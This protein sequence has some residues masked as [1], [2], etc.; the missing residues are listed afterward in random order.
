MQ[1]WSQDPDAQFV[2]PKQ[3]GPLGELPRGVC[4][5]A[6]AGL[7]VG[8][9]KVDNLE[10]GAG[11]GDWSNGHIGFLVI[12]N[13]YVQSILDILIRFL[14]ILRFLHIPTILNITI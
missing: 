6:R 5:E 8:D 14:D 3:G 11:D 9:G 1:Y 7:V 10:A 13:I 12:V 2:G 4:D